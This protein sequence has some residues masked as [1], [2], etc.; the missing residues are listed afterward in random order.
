MANI[1][2]IETLGDTMT[3]ASPKEDPPLC[4]GFLNQKQQPKLLQHGRNNSSIEN[5]GLTPESTKTR[6]NQ[7]CVT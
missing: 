6:V 3:P 7:C 2:Y 4:V 1:T 5:V